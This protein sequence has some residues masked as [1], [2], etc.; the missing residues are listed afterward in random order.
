MIKRKPAHIFWIIFLLAFGGCFSEAFGCLCELK[1]PKQRVK[2]MK[3]NADTI[4]VGKGISTT[5]TESGVY[6]TVLLVEQIWKGEAENDY[7]VYTSGGCKVNFEVGK[8]YLVYAKRDQDQ[9]LVTEVCWGSALIS[10]RRP[11]I[12]R[13]GKPVR[14]S[15]MKTGS[16]R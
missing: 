7:D 3:K 4:F 12:K 14:T 10:E 5:R 8:S 11:D 13:L 6:K 9:K 16:V 1:S 2:F 15:M